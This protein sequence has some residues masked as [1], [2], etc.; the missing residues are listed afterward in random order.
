MTITVPASRFNRAERDR[1]GLG[2]LAQA[3]QRL[4][5]RC[6]RIDSGEVKP[7]ALNSAR[8]PFRDIARLG[9]SCC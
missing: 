6:T 8:E 2:E 7:V 4:G 9:V 1:V 5:E 3:G